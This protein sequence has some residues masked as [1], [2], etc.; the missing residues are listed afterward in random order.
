MD[1]EG[2]MDTDV[3]VDVD[4]GSSFDVVFLLSFSIPHN[5]RK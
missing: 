2:N 5:V 4:V 3:D 1:E